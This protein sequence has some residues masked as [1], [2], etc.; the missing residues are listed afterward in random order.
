MLDIREN[1]LNVKVADFIRDNISKKR[2]FL[3]CSH[4]TSVLFEYMSNQILVLLG[5]STLRG[6]YP[7]DYANITACGIPIPYPTSSIDHFKFEFDNE[8][9]KEIADPFYRDLIISYLINHK[10]V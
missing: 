10:R 7:L 8:G 3:S 2:L 6:M 5:L 1:N 4:P 9:S